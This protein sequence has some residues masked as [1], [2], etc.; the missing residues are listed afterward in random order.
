M[1]SYIQS[2]WSQGRKIYGN[3]SWREA[4]RTALHT[5]RSLKNKKEISALEAYFKAYEPMPNLLEVHVGLYELMSRIF[6]YKDSTVTERLEAII[7]HF[8]YMKQY[9]KDETIQFLYGSDKEPYDAIGEEPVRGF[10]VWQDPE[11][12]MKA[13][14]FFAAGQRKEGLVTLLLTIDGHGIY[15]AYFRFG[16]GFHQEPAMWIGTIQ[17]YKEGL[18]NAKKATKKMYGYRPKSFIMFLLRELAK[19]MQVESI[20]AVSDAGFY[21]NTHLIRG[22]K[23]KVAFLDP[24]WEEVEGAVCEDARFY[25]IPIEEYRKPIEE[26]KSQK[27]S[28]YRNRYALLDQ[29]ADDIR[30]MMCAYLK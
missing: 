9:L 15:H 24:L 6:L 16:K 30:E 28:Q 17:G 13:R 14:L 21:A 4:R 26:I 5:V 10:L 23:A 11:L 7:N 8:D 22:H 1:F 19:S 2:Q 27:R 25:Q 29:Y 20:Y 3:H 12:E 18:D